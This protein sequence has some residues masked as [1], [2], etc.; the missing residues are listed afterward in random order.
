[1]FEISLK[2]NKKFTCDS[3][4]T[5]LQ[6]AKNNGTLLNITVFQLGAEAV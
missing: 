3:Q 6:G 2:N 5:I 1:M 4:T